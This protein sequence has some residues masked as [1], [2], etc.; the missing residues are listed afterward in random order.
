MTGCD[1]CGAQMDLDRDASPLCSICDGQAGVA[2]GRI[3][4]A[5]LNARLNVA[6][7]DYRRAMGAQHAAIEFNRTLDP[8]NP[9]G[10][11]A[12]QNANFQVE[13]ASTQYR[14]ALRE[15]VTALARRAD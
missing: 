9:D 1:Q 13:L 8:N 5:E 11:M 12:M 14:E 3:T 2:P 15:F 10:S 4:M 6:R 7:D